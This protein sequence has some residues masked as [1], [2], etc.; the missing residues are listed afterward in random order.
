MLSG[1]RQ[2]VLTRHTLAQAYGVGVEVANGPSG[3]VAFR[4]GPVDTDP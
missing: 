2:E 1:T 3:T 4:V